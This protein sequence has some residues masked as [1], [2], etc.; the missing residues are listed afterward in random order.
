M[1]LACLRRFQ[2][3]ATFAMTDQLILNVDDFDPVRFLRTE[4]LQRAGFRVVEAGSAEEA[5]L[6]A[7]A[8]APDLVLLDVDLPDSDGF[9]LCAALL[10]ARPSLP[11]I[12]ISAVHLAAWTRDIGTAVGASAYLREPVDPQMLVSRVRIALRGVKDEPSIFWVVTDILGVILEISPPAA[13]MLAPGRY[14]VAGRSLL[15]FFSR[16]REDW[17][18]ALYRAA[19]GELVQKEGVIRREHRRPVDVD[20]EITAVR[21]AERGEPQFTWMF[22]PTPPAEDT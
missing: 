2:P 15:R 20:V 3:H 1:Y 21:N 9:Q 5:R 19:N 12:L 7:E 13:E 14:S 4:A 6:R 22:R 8:D 17:A 18:A 10:R 11:V 16:D